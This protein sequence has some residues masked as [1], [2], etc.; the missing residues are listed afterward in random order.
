MNTNA[1]GCGRLIVVVLGLVTTAGC[2][3]FGRRWAAAP[4]APTGGA[5]DI[6]GRWQGRWVSEGT[7]H[8]GGL[9]GVIA[10]M[11]RA[12]PLAD[13]A[14][15]AAADDADAYGAPSPIPYR[16]QFDAT[17][18]GVLH[19]GQT[20]ELQAVPHADRE[21]VQ[22]SDE[23]DLGPLAGGVYYYVGEANRDTF[24]CTYKSKDDYGYFEMRRPSTGKRPGIRGASG[25]TVKSST[26]ESRRHGGGRRRRRRRMEDRG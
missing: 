17:W 10:P 1:R 19:F 2:S 11:R 16:V 6:A 8:S 26:T 23:Q 3:D 4:A 18:G 22:F 13:E 15:L 25:G 5:A 12:S 21:L 24:F 20:I 7:G 14:E 9:R